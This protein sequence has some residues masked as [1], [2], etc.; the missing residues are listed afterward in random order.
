[1]AIAWVL[2]ERAFDLQLV[3]PFRSITPIYIIAQKEN[4]APK[5]M[6]GFAEKQLGLEAAVDNNH[7]RQPAVFGNVQ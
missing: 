7:K 4:R 3:A 5:K 6:R 2:S 1:M